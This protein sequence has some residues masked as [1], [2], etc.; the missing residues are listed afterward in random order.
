[1]NTNAIIVAPVNC[2]AHDNLST[3]FQHI[4]YIFVKVRLLSLTA[5]AIIAKVKFCTETIQNATSRG[6]A[7]IIYT[8]MEKTKTTPT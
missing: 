7:H 3:C 1:M 6:S 5:G 2:A 8:E 4:F